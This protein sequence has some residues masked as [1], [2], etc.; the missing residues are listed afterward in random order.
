M[1]SGVTKS[2]ITELNASVQN[3]SRAAGDSGELFAWLQSV[4]GHGRGG[5]KD[6]RAQ[7]RSRVSD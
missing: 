3:K 5:I 6:H 2:S 7:S 4:H 1:P